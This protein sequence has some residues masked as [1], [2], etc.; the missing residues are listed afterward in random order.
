M[1]TWIKNHKAYLVSGIGVAGGVALICLGHPVAGVTT[2]LSA[3]NV[4]AYRLGAG[5]AKE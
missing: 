2:I 1:L 4:G 3:L 5:Q